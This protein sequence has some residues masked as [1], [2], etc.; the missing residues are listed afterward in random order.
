MTKEKIIFLKFARH[1]DPFKMFTWDLEV[2]KSHLQ[3]I[4]YPNIKKKLGVNGLVFEQYEI[5][6]GHVFTTFCIIS[7]K[8]ARAQFKLW[9]AR[10]TLLLIEMDSKFMGMLRNV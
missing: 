4:F 5:Q 8:G 7:P 1:Y 3:F 6:K 2:I 10:M 9:R